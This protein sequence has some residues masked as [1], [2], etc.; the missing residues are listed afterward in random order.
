MHVQTAE[1][2]ERLTGMA[3]ASRPTDRVTDI[4]AVVAG[5]GNRRLYKSLGA[6][7]I[8]EG[9]QSMNPSTADIVDAIELAGA[10]RWSC[11]P[12]TAT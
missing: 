11:C 10:P 1:R 4:V 6:A 2:Q 12:T 3:V 5:E 9:G 8:V 7:S